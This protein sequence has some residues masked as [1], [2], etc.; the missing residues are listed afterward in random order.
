MKTKDCST[1]SVGEKLGVKV[2]MKVLIVNE[3]TDYYRW[4]NILSNE[5]IVADFK[6]SGSVDFIHVFFNNYSEL[7]KMMHTLKERLG[8]TGQLW[9]SWVK[10]SSPLATDLNVNIVRKV[11]INNGLV[12]IKICAVNDD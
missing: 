2:G 10:K 5:L 6:H 7:N 12:D 3:P 8:N 9:C 4:L 11:G 1:K